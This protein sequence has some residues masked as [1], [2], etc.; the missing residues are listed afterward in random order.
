MRRKRVL[1]W[2]A[3]AAVGVTAT[4]MASFGGGPMTVPFLVVATVIIVKVDK[5]VAVSGLLVGFGASWLALVTGQP[6]AEG[7]SGGS[8]VVQALIGA[9]PLLL[10]MLALIPLFIRA[11]RRPG[12]ER[13]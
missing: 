12:L 3:M 8:A 7:A 6:I 13:T 5:L 10:G 2:A 4:L 1:L 11:L 9:V